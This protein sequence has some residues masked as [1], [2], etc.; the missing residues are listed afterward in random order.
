[1]RA[2]EDELALEAVDEAPSGGTGGSK[3]DRISLAIANMKKR[4]AGTSEALL[5]GL[6][7]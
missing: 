2:V 6:V 7:L 4:D 3:G 5:D 1:M